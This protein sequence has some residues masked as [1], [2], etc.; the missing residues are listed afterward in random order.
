MDHNPLFGKICLDHV[1]HILQNKQTKKKQT[2][3]KE[4]EKKTKP[5]YESAFCEKYLFSQLIC[6]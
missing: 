5:F 6:Q 1:S 4:V 2:K 3:T